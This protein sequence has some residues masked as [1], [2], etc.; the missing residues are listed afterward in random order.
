M[1]GERINTRSG[2]YKNQLQASEKDIANWSKVL[3]VLSLFV[4]VTFY[5]ADGDRPDRGASEE[6]VVQKAR[7]LVLLRK[8]LSNT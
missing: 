6:V 5:A 3:L 2:N 7:A 8:I 1:T 4:N